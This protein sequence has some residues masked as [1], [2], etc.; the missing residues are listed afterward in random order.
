[1]CMVV[2]W[3]CGLLI[4]SFGMCSCEFFNFR[5][6]VDLCL[7]LNYKQYNVIDLEACLSHKSTLGT[8]YHK[9]ESASFD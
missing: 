2:I 3:Y 5:L 8:D 4:V 1:M 6:I 9:L 7:N